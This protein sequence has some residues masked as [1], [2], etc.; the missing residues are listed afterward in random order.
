[1]INQVSAFKKLFHADILQT[2]IKVGIYMAS[3]S[4]S[5]LSW[6]K[7]PEVLIEDES[8]VV[9]QRDD[10]SE[11]FFEGLLYYPA[12]HATEILNAFKNVHTEK[13]VIDFIHNWGFLKS[14]A[15]HDSLTS[16]RESHKRLEEFN[17]ILEYLF[18]TKRLNEDL[19]I[20]YLAGVDRDRDYSRDFSLEERHEYRAL[21]DEVAYNLNLV[22]QPDTTYKRVSA[23][24]YEKVS[25]QGFEIPGDRT[26]INIRIR[27][28]NVHEILKTAQKLRDLSSA[29]HYKKAYDDA[30]KGLTDYYAVENMVE[31]WLNTNPDI[32]PISNKVM[33]KNWER[34]YPNH[35]WI[36]GGRELSLNEFKIN[37]VANVGRLIFLKGLEED[38]NVYLDPRTGET[39]ILFHNLQVFIFYTLLAEPASIP[40]RCFD[41]KCNQ[42][43][44]PSRKGQKYCPPTFRGRSLC[45]QRHGQALRRAKNKNRKE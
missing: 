44:F 12:E 11:E 29:L 2:L 15:D 6:R 28:E 42:L 3:P 25:F 16:M 31:E 30:E 20:D 22:R 32:L 14:V 34:N 17:Y 10:E 7:E 26:G 1:M 36:S 24:K 45:E 33:M 9:G 40:G 37:Q 23:N 8:L 21:V 18:H 43:F 19:S 4:T 39:C 27:G 35:P 38:T 5:F 41:P 13:D